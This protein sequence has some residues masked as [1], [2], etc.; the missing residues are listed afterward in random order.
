MCKALC[1]LSVKLRLFF[2]TKFFTF[3]C[4]IGIG[5]RSSGSGPQFF[6]LCSMMLFSQAFCF[7]TQVA[8]ASLREPCFLAAINKN[9]S[10]SKM[11]FVFFLF[12]YFIP[13]IIDRSVWLTGSFSLWCCVAGCWLLSNLGKLILY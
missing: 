3:C 9:K 11:C 5:F 7:T 12:I 2:S 13:Q 1:K 4:F 8:C 10:E 6:I